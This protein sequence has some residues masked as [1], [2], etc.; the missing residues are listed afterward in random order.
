[1]KKII[2]ISIVTGFLFAQASFAGGADVAAG[3]ASFDGKCASCHGAKGMKPIL[4]TYPKLGGQNALY[5]V[6]QI[7]DFQSSTR[8]DAT[9]NAMANLVQG[10]EI[11]NV[12][13]YLE[14]VGKEAK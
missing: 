9:M 11:E 4:A 10:A 13:A 7:K 6:K 3:K 2:T 14:S 1:V 12:A 5:L 8:K